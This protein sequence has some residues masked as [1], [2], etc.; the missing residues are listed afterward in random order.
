M[1]AACEPQRHH[2]ELRAGSVPL[3]GHLPQASRQQL[4]ITFH[5]ASN[6]IR[7]YSIQGE[8]QQLKHIRVHRFS[9][10]YETYE[11]ILIPTMSINRQVSFQNATDD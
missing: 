2:R 5:N 7:K 10:G 1:A 9:V 8:Y 4:N 3:G 6:S 11:A